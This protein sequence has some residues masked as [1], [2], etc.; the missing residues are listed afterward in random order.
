MSHW[1]T[2]WAQA[3][4]DIS[5]MYPGKR[6]RTYILS[7]ICDTE[8]EELRLRFSNF[9]GR[10]RTKIGG[11]SVH[12]GNGKIIPI[13][14]SGKTSAVLEP[15][16]DLYSDPCR[17]F[18]P[19]GCA[20]SIS[21]YVEE[22][23][24]SGNQLQEAIVCSKKGNYVMENQVPAARR[25]TFGAFATLPLLS[26]VEVKAKSGP[27]T[28]LCIG[29]SITQQGQWVNALRELYRANK[30]NT[31]ILNKGIGGNRLM[32]DSTGMLS[33]FGKSVRNRF[34]RDALQDPGVTDLI[35]AIG[36]NDLAMANNPQELA[37]CNAERQIQELCYLAETAVQAGIRVYAA[38]I[39]PR[40]G[41]Q[42]WAEPQE[43]QRLALNEFLRHSTAFA[44]VIDFDMVCSTPG[45][46]SVLASYCDSG[47]HLHPNATG[48]HLMA[49]EAYRVLNKV[50]VHEHFQES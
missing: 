37:Q 29:D 16:A 41:F 49:H 38:T 27:R 12:A 33:M 39:T 46:R 22:G 36:T 19:A 43:S 3:H 7:I 42:K 31:V 20:L 21:I 24:Q 13:L 35:I 23:A 25:G 40:Y 15:E 48:G 10:T 18:I 11:A 4:T 5:R 34:G 30:E 28:I 47:D 1:T 32:A 45:K 44:G 8:G 14:F 50:C 2:I 26:S 9:E 17:E 6:K